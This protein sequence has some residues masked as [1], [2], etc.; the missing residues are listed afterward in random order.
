MPLL[1]LSFTSSPSL[2]ILPFTSIFLF[3]LLPLHPSDP[4]YPFLHC[5]LILSLSL[6]LMSPSSNICIPFSFF[7]STPILSTSFPLSSLLS[8]LAAVGVQAILSTSAPLHLFPPRQP[9]LRP[10]PSLSLPPPSASC[11]HSPFC[12]RP[13]TWACR[14]HS[15]SS[16]RLA[17]NSG[18]SCISN[19]RMSLSLHPKICRDSPQ[20]E[21]HL[22]IKLKVFC[23]QII[24]L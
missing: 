2:F 12:R 22:K 18:L 23:R 10:S 4:C 15:M 24:A 1:S 21:K 19:H 8:S 17:K 3:S 11:L 13:S 14:L 5:S 6:V 20:N 16:R 9:T 7:N